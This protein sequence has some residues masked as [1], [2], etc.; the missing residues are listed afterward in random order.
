[1]RKD[2]VIE[3]FCILT[4]KVGNHLKNRWAHDC[5]CK[6]SHPD[7]YSFRFE[8]PVFTFIERAIDRLIEEEK[9]EKNN[10]A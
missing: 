9:N 4:V 5:F 2:E 10:P 3:R 1:M 7:E 8:E 6:F